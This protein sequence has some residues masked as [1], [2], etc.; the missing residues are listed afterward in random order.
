M[1][2][3]NLFSSERSS[4]PPS[5]CACQPLRL[6]HGFAAGAILL[7][8]LFLASGRLTAGTV[9]SLQNDS[10]AVAVDPATMAVEL[11]S[12][13]LPAIL[14]S[15]AQTNLG[16]VAG[17]ESSAAKAQWSLPERKVSSRSE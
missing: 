13:A 3:M 11:R 9:I 5:G 16:N 2:C 7:A 8:P 6:W 1:I 14:V 15:A 4:P 10:C 12:G 17:L